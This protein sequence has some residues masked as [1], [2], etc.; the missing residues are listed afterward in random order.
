MPAQ[1][2]FF[3][4]VPKTPLHA[5]RGAR[6]DN[7]RRRAPTNT[8][9]QLLP[10]PSQEPLAHQGFHFHT[11]GGKQG[12]NCQVTTRIKDAPPGPVAQESHQPRRE[13]H[14]KAKAGAPFKLW[15]GRCSV[16][17]HRHLTG[18][19]GRAFG[20]CTRL[21][22]G[23][24]GEETKRGKGEIWGRR[25]TCM[26]IRGWPA[27]VSSLV[28]HL[29]STV[30]PISLLNP[31]CSCEVLSVG[32]GTTG[33]CLSLRVRPC[34]VGSWGDQECPGHP[35]THLC[36]CVPATGAGLQ[37]CAGI[38]ETGVCGQTVWAQLLGR[39]HLIIFI[40]LFPT[41]GAP[42]SSSSWEVTGAVCVTA[43]C[44]FMHVPPG[45]TGSFL[46]LGARSGVSLTPVQPNSLTLCSSNSGWHFS[47]S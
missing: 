7:G 44:G 32:V 14:H 15:K 4:G 21:T 26:K 2:P 3:G 37:P 31:I 27:K 8:L 18:C 34:Q 47:F 22:M 23:C 41:A 36:A 38:R 45:N 28:L 42:S 35:C 19:T 13:I 16:Q 5:H 1:S 11:P 43:P 25:D 9:P 12:H 40:C 10:G 30:C 17:G 24:L 20:A 29:V 33:V 39:I 46:L 6:R